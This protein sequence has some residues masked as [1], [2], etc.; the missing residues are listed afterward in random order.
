MRIY[1]VLALSTAMVLSTLSLSA[2]SWRLWQSPNGGTE[3]LD[4]SQS[5]WDTGGGGMAGTDAAPIPIGQSFTPQ[6]SP[7][8][9]MDFIIYNG[10]DYEHQP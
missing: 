5:V 10:W 7:L 8:T 1:Q 2:A 6:A 9:R 3:V 4:Q